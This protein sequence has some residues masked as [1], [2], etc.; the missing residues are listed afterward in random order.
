MNYD[1]KCKII[2]ERDSYIKN[3]EIKFK[4]LQEESNKI[5]SDLIDQLKTEKSGKPNF[6]YKFVIHIL[7]F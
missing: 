5:K 7:F 4:E 3:L 1:S 2:Q 6:Y